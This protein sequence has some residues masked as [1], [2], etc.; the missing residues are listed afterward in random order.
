MK[1]FVTGSNGMMGWGIKKVFKKDDLILT[2]H[3]NLDITK[4][5]V[6]GNPDIIFHL[7]AETNHHRAEL[8]PKDTYYTNHTGTMNMVEHA[9]RLNIP[10]VYIGTCGM[11]SGDKE[12]YTEEDQPEALNHYGRSKYYGEQDVRSWKKHYIVRCGWAM[13]GGV[14][15]DHK[16][17]GLIMKQIQDGAKVI[18]AIN[19]VYGSPT[20]TPD[21]AKA[22]KEIINHCDY[23]TYHIAPPDKASRADVAKQIVDIVETDCKVQPVSYEFYHGMFG[24]QVPYTKREVLNT[25]KIQR[26]GIKMRPWRDALTEYLGEFYAD[27]LFTKHGFTAE[28]A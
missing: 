2:T 6:I 13:G 8:N 27:S 16:F 22:I 9:R 21:F 24:L 25:D 10:I 26:M 15:I 28:T 1:I 23:G 14:G 18:Y 20:Y 11:Y 4:D 17:V 7:A 19:D 12:S 3:K 5:G